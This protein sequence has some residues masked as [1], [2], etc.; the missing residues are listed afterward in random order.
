MSESER[1]ATI[2]KVNVKVTADKKW[3]ALAK[4]AARTPEKMYL[5]V[6]GVRP[7]SAAE[8]TLRGKIPFSLRAFFYKKRVDR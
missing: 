5:K 1:A 2:F 6:V 3:A 8:F 7:E 4:G